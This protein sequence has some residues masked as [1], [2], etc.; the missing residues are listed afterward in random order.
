MTY[1][2]TWETRLLNL[3]MLDGKQ[4]Q[5]EQDWGEAVDAVLC[6]WSDKLVDDP[7][8]RDD[9]GHAIVALIWPHVKGA[10]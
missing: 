5:T 7:K 4:P 2:E 3:A 10:T 9:L 6:E 1:H 8:L